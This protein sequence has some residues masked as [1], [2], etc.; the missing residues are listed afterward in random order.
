MLATLVSR[1]FIAALTTTLLFGISV[2]A[3]L[4]QQIPP[5]P[6]PVPVGLDASTTAIIVNDVNESTCR[7]QPNCTGGVVPAVGALLDRAREAGALVVFSTPAG[8]GSPVLPEVGPA[9]G[10]PVVL[11]YGQ[12]RFFSTA[13][14]DMLRARHVATAVVTGWKTNGS[15]LY[16]AYR[17]GLLRYTVV[18]PVDATSAGT[19]AE[20]AIG[21]FQLLDQLGGN[22]T[23]QPL[24]P[25]RVTLSRTDLITFE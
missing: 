9:P 7:P 11:A 21:R 14:D 25:G 24:V 20:D 13:M 3:V 18:V 5:T 23:N 12:D 4:A 17:A 6:D 8:T 15:V 2:P 10:E 22:A 16:T 1:R 19:E